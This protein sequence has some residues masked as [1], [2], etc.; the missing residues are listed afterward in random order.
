MALDPEIV[1]R[2]N[3]FINESQ[4]IEHRVTN[5]V[6]SSWNSLGS[7][8][9]AD[10]AKFARQ[11]APIIE[12]AQARV[13]SLTD[14]YL[15]T[16]ESIITDSRVATLGVPSELMT[17]ESLRGVPVNEVYQ[18]P[19]LTIYNGLSE[20]KPLDAMVSKGEQRALTLVRTGLQL[21]Q[22]HSSRYVMAQKPRIVG[23]RRVLSGAENC[24]LCSI[25]STQRYNKAELMPIHPGCD[26]KVM[27]IY[28]T[29]DPGQII[30][31]QRLDET[32]TA[33][34]S[35]TGVS[36]AGGREVDYRQVTIEKHGEIGPVL[37]IKGQH[38][39]SGSDLAA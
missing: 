36:D 3:A 30:D 29:Q 37:A 16:I 8:R 19:G 10:I 18:R 39:T 23:H 34:K 33:V 26:C 9:D 21:A 12:G 14:A 27:P 13:G 6:R 20:G 11:V 5:F 22:T 15:S 1:R 24:A 28:G 38:F 35:K 32:H 7:W 2:L 17:T 4:A 25:A 31:Q